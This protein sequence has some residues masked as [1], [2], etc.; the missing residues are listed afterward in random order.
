MKECITCGA[1]Y[2]LTE[3]KLPVHDRDRINCL[4]CGT[5]LIDWDG[6]LM[7]AVKTLSGPKGEEGPDNR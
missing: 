6:N 1:L 4:F 2:D 5:L 3:I 7:Y